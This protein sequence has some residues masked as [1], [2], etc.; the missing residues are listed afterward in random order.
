MLWGGGS[1]AVAFL[2]T[3][4]VND[5]VAFAVDINPYK[6]GTFLA[7]TG[8]EVVGPAALTDYKPDVVIIMNPIYHE[9]IRKDLAAMDLAPELFDIDQNV[10]PEHVS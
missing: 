2:T 6:H 1:K 5:E 4:G 8:H 9:E 7:M 3:L 10:A